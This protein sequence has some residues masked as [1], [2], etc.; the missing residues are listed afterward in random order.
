M[1]R[2][3]LKY[4]ATSQHHIF[5]FVHH[6]IGFYG[7]LFFF[8]GKRYSKY[9]ED[10]SV[11]GINEKELNSMN[12]HIPGMKSLFLIIFPFWRGKPS[13]SSPLRLK[14]Q[15]FGLTKSPV[16]TIIFHPKIRLHLFES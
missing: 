16:H 11:G 8:A 6:M 15:I 7:L 10:M 12:K 3:E 4:L 14:R 13:F 9:D 5:A 2:V 1:Q